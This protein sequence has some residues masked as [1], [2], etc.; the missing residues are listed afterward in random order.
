MR[1]VFSAGACRVSGRPPDQLAR[2]VR[3]I[4]AGL[5]RSACADVTA[6]FVRRPHSVYLDLT[7]RCPTCGKRADMC[8]D[9]GDDWKR[10]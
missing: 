3:D 5:E 6:P 1:Q 7:L 8:F 10:R 4:A 2:E 9:H